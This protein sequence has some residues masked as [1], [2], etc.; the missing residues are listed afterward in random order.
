MRIIPVSVVLF[1]ILSIVTVSSCRCE[2]NYKVVDLSSF[3]K[4][5]WENII[6]LELGQ[7]LYVKLKENGTTNYTWIVF[8][9][10][11]KL[12][13]LLDVL[14]LTKSFYE[15]DPNPLG[16]MGVGGERT[17]E[18]TALEEGSGNLFLV[19]DQTQNPI[20]AWE[21]YADENIKVLKIKVHH[22]FID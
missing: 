14:S 16:L 12:F 10:F 13:G 3:D 4:P 9:E 6:H 20:K 15:E 2:K 18:F 11:L 21:D 1:L 22:G 5:N 19:Y 7:K 8:Q 17:L